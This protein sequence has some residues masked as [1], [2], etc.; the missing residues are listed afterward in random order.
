MNIDKLLSRSL[1]NVDECRQISEDTF[2][3]A[4]NVIE[5]K[6]RKKNRKKFN[7]SFREFSAVAAFALLLILI[8]TLTSYYNKCNTPTKPNISQPQSSETT[9]KESAEQVSTCTNTT[10]P[11]ANTNTLT[12]PISEY[13]PFN[14]NVKLTY[15]GNGM[16]Y[17]SNITYVDFIKGNRIQLRTNNSGTEV[18]QVREIKDG[19][20]R[21]ITSRPEC[22]YKEDLTSVKN[23]KPEILLKEPLVKGTTWTLT[24]GRK[25]HI[26]SIDAEISTPIGTYKAIEVTTEGKSSIDLAYYAKGVGLIKFITVLSDDNQIS[27]TLSKIEEKVPLTQEIKI[28]NNDVEAN[29]YFYSTTKL[30]FNTND[31]TKTIFEKLFKSSPIKNFQC[32]SEKTKINNLYLNTSEETVYVDFSKEFMERCVGTAGEFAVLYNIT[33]TLGTYYNVNKVMLTVEGKPYQSGHIVMKEGEA[34]TVDIRNPEEYKK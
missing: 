1:K 34:F 21:L 10:E 6:K 33:S 19:E 32:I 14:A 23:N 11:S 7:F 2:E 24:D 20:L 17:A 27:T 15:T 3:E 29:K 4:W 12:G 26:T 8:P 5:K 18:C 22:Y 9:A 30:A 31:S 13:Y 16:E 25:C 28:F